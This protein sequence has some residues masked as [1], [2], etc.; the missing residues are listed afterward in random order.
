MFPN[1]MFFVYILSK[2]QA[3]N[4]DLQEHCANFGSGLVRDCY[5]AKAPNLWKLLGHCTLNFWLTKCCW[6]TFLCFLTFCGLHF[7]SFVTII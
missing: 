5:M 7:V 1:A 4:S 2:L 3:I 6:V